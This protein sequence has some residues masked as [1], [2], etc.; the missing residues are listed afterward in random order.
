MEQ[1]TTALVYPIMLSQFNE[2]QQRLYAA[3]EAL[4]RG[5]GG[6]S[7]VSR[8]TGISRVTITFGIKQLR[9]GVIQDGRIRKVGAGRKLLS[10]RQGVY[11]KSHECIPDS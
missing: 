1:W 5:F 3:S 9:L 10:H 6:I 8:E 7:E 11:N 4:R 2:K